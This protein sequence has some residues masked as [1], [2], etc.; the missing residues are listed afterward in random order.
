[1]QQILNEYPVVLTQTLAWGDMDAYQHINNIVFFRYFQDARVAYFEKID[2]VTY[3]HKTNVGPVVAS[4]TCDYRAP[5]TYPDTILIGVRT[6]SIEGKRLTMK[7]CVYSESLD[8]IAAEGTA[9][10]VFYDFESETSCS[11]P[12]EIVSL[13]EATESTLFS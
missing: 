2:L 4:T 5:L 11:I 1:M 7:Y 13:I 3:K 8:K 12:N 9:L 6:E 10:I